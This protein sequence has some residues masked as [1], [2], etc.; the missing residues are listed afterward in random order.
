MISINQTSKIFAI[1]V[2]AVFM[3]LVLF[4]GCTDEKQVV[5]TEIEVQHDTVFVSII[6]VDAINAS[7]DS[8][9]QGLPITLTVQY[10]KGSQVG[11]VTINWHATGGHFD[12]EQGDTVTWTSPDDPGVYTITV[13]LDDGQYIGIG[14]RMVGVG[15]YVPTTSPFYIGVD[16]CAGCHGAGSQH[17]EYEEWV[18]TG[19]AEAWETLQGSGHAGSSCY[20]CHAAGWDYDSTQATPYPIGNTGNSGFDEAPIEKF[21]NVQC[22]NCHDPGSDHAQAPSPTNIN[23]HWDVMV[24]GKCHDGTHHPFLTEWMQS[25]HNFSPRTGSCEGC[26]EGVAAAIRLDGEAASYPLGPGNFYGSGSIAERPDYTE[27]PAQ[28]ANCI[29]CHSPHSAENPGQLRTVADVQLVENF[30]RTPVI[31]EGGV[32]RLCMQ[33]HHA[34]RG[35][36]AQIISGSGHFGPHANPQ[37]DMLKAESIFFGVADPSFPW[38]GPSHLNVENSCKT[39]H[40]ATREFGGG[41]GGAAVVGHEFIPKPEACVGCHGPITA[42]TDI[43]ALEDFDGDGTIEGVQDEILGL[44]DILETD[45]IATGLDTTGVGFLGAIGDTSISTVLQRQA[46][47]NWAFVEEDKSKGVHNPDFAVQ[48][49]QQTILYVG[50]TLPKNATIVRNENEVVGSW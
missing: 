20:P 16:A 8:V 35:P 22:E 18:E 21:V 37:A 44:L 46:G 4:S 30:G 2:I 43:L 10:T 5:K 25:P 26:H 15:M 32:G 47:W 29:T 50:G 34:R 6:S 9:T 39:C 23:K 45:I 49:L 48:V 38:A 11:N 19:H 24:C 17:P 28:P 3:G 31:N 27:V 7:L 1:V 33:C 42:F 36:E 40:L 12:V 41:P 14:S 13:H